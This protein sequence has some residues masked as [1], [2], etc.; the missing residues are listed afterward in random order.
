MELGGRALHFPRVG[1]TRS[2]GLPCDQGLD[3]GFNLYLSPTNAEPHR[4]FAAPRVCVT[5]IPLRADT[6]VPEIPGPLIRQTARLVPETH[7]KWDETIEGASRVPP[8]E[9][10]QR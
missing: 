8:Q 2:Y 4:V 1:K 6:A 3:W 7:C 10:S 5:G 9:R